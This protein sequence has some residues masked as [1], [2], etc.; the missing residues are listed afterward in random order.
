MRSRCLCQI[1]TCG[2]FVC[3][4]DIIVHMEP[5]G[6]MRMLACLALQLNIWKNILCM[7]KFFHLRVLNP[8]KNFEHAVGKWKE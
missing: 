1:C 7:A 2:L 3:T 6:F 8:S 5:Q 4:G